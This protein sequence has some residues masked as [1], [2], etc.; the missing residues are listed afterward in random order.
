M[1]LTPLEVRMTTAKKARESSA[2]VKGSF[3][4]P[5]TDLKVD[6]S[7]HA[8]DEGM[9]DLL[10]T[11]FLSSRSACVKLVDHIHQVGNLDTFSL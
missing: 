11:N 3:A 2:L 1:L 5:A 8:G 6:K 4:T 10:K 7:S 9:S